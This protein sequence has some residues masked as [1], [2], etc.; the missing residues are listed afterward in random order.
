MI[1][2][3]YHSGSKKPEPPFLLMAATARGTPAHTKGG[4]W[5]FWKTVPITHIAPVPAKDE[6]QRR[7]FTLQ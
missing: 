1:V 7:G 6:L 5:L 4:I 3:V 2:D